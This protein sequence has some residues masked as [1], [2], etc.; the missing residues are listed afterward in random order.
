MTY[1]IVNTEDNLEKRIFQFRLSQFKGHLTKDFLEMIVR[2]IQG[3]GIKRNNYFLV[4]TDAVY[5]F[6]QQTIESTIFMAIVRHAMNR[7]CKHAMIL[8]K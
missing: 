5:Q 6:T 1:K 7:G 2:P 4:H 8:D 3:P